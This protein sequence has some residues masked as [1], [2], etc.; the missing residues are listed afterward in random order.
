MSAWIICLDGQ[1][2]DNK[3]KYSGTEGFLCRFCFPADYSI[4]AFFPVFLLIKIRKIIGDFF[5]K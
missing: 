5:I 4:A 3:E 2:I 1:T